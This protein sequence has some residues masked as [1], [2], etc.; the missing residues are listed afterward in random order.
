LVQFV[1]VAY[2]VKE[3]TGVSVSRQTIENWILNYKNENKE[4]KNRYSGYYIF[5]VEWV[6]IQGQWNYRFTLFDSK[7]KYC[8]CG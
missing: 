2:R 4:L 7:T 5:D 6:K 1:N 3:D 8:C